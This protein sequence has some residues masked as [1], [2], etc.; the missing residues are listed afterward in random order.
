[1]LPQGG[2]GAQ[3]HRGAWLAPC[4]TG[5]LS[6]CSTGSQPRIHWFPIHGI[7]MSLGVS[8]LLEGGEEKKKKDTCLPCPQLAQVKSSG[9]R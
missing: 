7:R 3:R 5:R 1:M 6:V 8:V 4:A 9:E 2:R